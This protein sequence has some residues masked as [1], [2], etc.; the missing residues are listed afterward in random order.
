MLPTGVVRA[1]STG[2]QLDNKEHEEPK[3]F[4]DKVKIMWKKY[5]RVAIVT[6]FGVYIG[7]LSSLFLALDFGLFNSATF[8]FDHAAAIAKVCL[9][10][11]A[12][13]AVSMPVTSVTTVFCQ[14]CDLY[15]SATGHTE[16]AQ[17]IKGHPTGT[18]PTLHNPTISCAYGTTSLFSPYNYHSWHLCCGLVYDKVYR[19]RAPADHRGHRAAH[20]QVLAATDR[21]EVGGRTA[22]AGGGGRKAGGR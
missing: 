18:V 15:E 4:K 12:P 19:A 13:F 2:P 9:L 3:S 8:G 16:L 21:R 14:V 1:L 22:R 7:T 10:Y 6:Y 17:Y 11:C 20:R 5:G